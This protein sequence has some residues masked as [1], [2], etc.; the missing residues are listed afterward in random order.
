MIDE[1]IKSLKLV[2]Y[3]EFIKILRLKK[4][5]EM[6]IKGDIWKSWTYIMGKDINYD[7]DIHIGVCVAEDVWQGYTIVYDL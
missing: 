1:M 6:R 3:A 4:K 2:K 7:D 5:E